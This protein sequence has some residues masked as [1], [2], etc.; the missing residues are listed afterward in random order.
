MF[1]SS[2]GLMQAAA[3]FLFTCRTK[4]PSQARG[5]NQYHR[6]GGTTE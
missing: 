4:W 5:E 3:A 2:A 6:G 1:P